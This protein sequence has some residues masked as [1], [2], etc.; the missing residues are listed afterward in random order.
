MKLS[1]LYVFGGMLPIPGTQRREMQFHAA[2][3]WQLERGDD[4]RVYVEKL[5][6]VDGGTALRKFVLQGVPVAYVEQV[7]APAVVEPLLAYGTADTSGI[8]AW[9]PAEPPPPKPRG[10]PRKGV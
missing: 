7:E 10:R 5:E 3:G 8:E 2:D 9:G 1:S 6:G 4:G